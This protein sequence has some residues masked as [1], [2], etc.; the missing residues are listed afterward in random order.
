MKSLL[1][2][3]PGDLFYIPAKN[4]EGV[5]G[6][7]IARYIELVDHNIGHLIEVFAQFRTELPA[8]IEDVDRRHRLFRPVLWSMYFP[9]CLPRWKVLFGDPTYDKAQSDYVSIAFAFDGKCWLGGK[10]GSCEKE[11]LDDFEPS[12]CWRSQHLIFRVNAHLAGLFGPSERYDHH[13]LPEACRENNPQAIQEVETLAI[14]VDR[15]FQAW[16]ST[17]KKIRAR[18]EICGA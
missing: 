8:S 12:I 10:T 1:S 11:M 5:H 3:H 7:V 16:Q 18:R 9:K 15:H 6:F 4:A 17:G 2:P 14:E 13:R